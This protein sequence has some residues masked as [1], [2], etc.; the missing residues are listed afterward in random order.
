MRYRERAVPLAKKSYRPAIS[1]ELRQHL[2][3]AANGSNST[4]VLILDAGAVIA[5]EKL[6]YP[7]DRKDLAHNLRVFLDQIDPQKE[8]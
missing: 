8:P 3:D 7:I 1:P 4:I 5:M 2:T 6:G